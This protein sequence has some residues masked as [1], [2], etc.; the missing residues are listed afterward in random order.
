[1]NEPAVRTFLNGSEHRVDLYNEDPIVHKLSHQHLYT[2]FWIL[3]VD[4][5]PME[6]IEI[7]EIA[8]LPVPTLIGNFIREFNFSK[9]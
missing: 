8:S 5:L 9:A 7:T 4:E 6:G 3:E 2:K 1:M